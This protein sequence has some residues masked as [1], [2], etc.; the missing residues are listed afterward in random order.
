MESIEIGEYSLPDVKNVLLLAF[1]EKKL[2]ISIKSVLRVPVVDKPHCLELQC[3]DNVEKY[4]NLYG[5]KKILG[6]YFISN[7]KDNTIIGVKHS[8][9]KNSYGN[10]IDIT[11][12]SDNRTYNSFLPYSLAKDKIIQL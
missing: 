10:L 5:G 8:I 1:I 4:C 3:H 6:Y 9:W 12:F 11:P 7:N 2:R